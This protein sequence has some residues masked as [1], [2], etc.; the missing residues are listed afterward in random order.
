MADA[1]LPP[2]HPMLF[3]SKSTS[4]CSES[5]T[6]VPKAT[7][8]APSTAPMAPKAQLLPG[9]EAGGQRDEK[10]KDDATPLGLATVPV[11]ARPDREG[12][13]VAALGSSREASNGGILLDKFYGIMIPPRSM[14]HLEG[15]SENSMELSNL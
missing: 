12:N 10:S 7:W 6:R 1:A 15:A 13:S 5:D 14:Q 9:N 4:C 11:L 3:V 8:M 2:P